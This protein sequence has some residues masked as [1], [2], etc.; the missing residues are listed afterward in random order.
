MGRSSQRKTRGKPPK[1]C[2]AESP[3]HDEDEGDLKAESMRYAESIRA[4]FEQTEAPA[5]KGPGRKKRKASPPPPVSAAKTP[6]IIIKFAKDAK[7]TPAQN[8]NNKPGEA[9]KEGQKNGLDKAAAAAPFDFV[10]EDPVKIPLSKAPVTPLPMVDGAADSSR[11]NSP[12]PMDTKLKLK[13]KVP[14]V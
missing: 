6:K 8:D 11:A 3:P 10:D 13:I 7:A 9:A 4:Q 12:V 5:K 1:K 2:L 14:P